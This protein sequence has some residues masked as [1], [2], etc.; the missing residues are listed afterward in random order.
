MNNN[1]YFETIRVSDGCGSLNNPDARPGPNYEW[2]NTC[3]G[4]GRWEKVSPDKEYWENYKKQ[5]DKDPESTANVIEKEDFNK[6]MKETEETVNNMSFKSDNVIDEEHKRYEEYCNL[7]QKRAR[8]IINDLGTCENEGCKFCK[9]GPEQCERFEEFNLMV[10]PQKCKHWQNK[11]SG[12]KYDKTPQT[13]TVDEFMAATNDA[14]EELEKLENMKKAEKETIEKVNKGSANVIRRTYEKLAKGVGWDEPYETYM[15][16]VSG[17]KKDL[18]KE[19]EDKLHKDELNSDL[20]KSI[21]A[22]FVGVADMHPSTFIDGYLMSGDEQIKAE[23]GQ[24]CAYAN[25]IYK[26][27]PNPLVQNPTF[28]HWEWKD[29]TANIYFRTVTVDDIMDAWMLEQCNRCNREKYCSDCRVY[30]VWNKDPEEREKVFGVEDKGEEALRTIE[31]LEED[32]SYKHTD[33]KNWYYM[34]SK[35]DRIESIDK[36]LEEL[37]D[38]TNALQEEK[39]ALIDTLNPL[40]FLYMKYELAKNYV[41]DRI[42]YEM[43]VKI[44]KTLDV[45]VAAKEPEKALRKEI[46]EA[47]DDLLEDTLH[48]DGYKSVLERQFENGTKCNLFIILKIKILSKDEN[49]SLYTSIQNK[50]FN[51]ECTL[52]VRPISTGI[53]K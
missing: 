53:V 43:L 51:V 15:D 44:Y 37:I 3:G 21:V 52:S 42:D 9:F 45:K 35:I 40:E 34:K 13:I 19:Q 24:Y 14:D 39:Q 33:N 41:L 8:K 28:T 23:P 38:K 47:F 4:G 5:Y 11:Y 25:K 20:F 22:K 46:E 48:S 16:R 18:T 17:K 32:T 50:S 49:A 12:E 10:G 2:I 29:D 30:K 31:N 1:K 6:L 7:S 36:Q 27:V 26:L